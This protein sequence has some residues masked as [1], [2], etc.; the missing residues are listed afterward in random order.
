[1]AFL[2]QYGLIL[3]DVRYSVINLIL[4]RLFWKPRICLYH[5]T[6]KT[7]R[8]RLRDR[9]TRRN[10]P[11]RIFRA[12][13][14]MF[15]AS[16]KSAD[17]ET[18][19]AKFESVRDEAIA[20]RKSSPSSSE[21]TSSSGRA[22]EQLQQR[23]AS[24]RRRVGQAPADRIR[25]RSLRRKSNRMSGG[26]PGSKL[27]R[28]DDPDEVVDIFPETCACGESLAG[29]PFEGRAGRQ[30]YDIAASMREIAEPRAHECRRGP[31]GKRA[32]AKFP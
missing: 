29:C 8:P 21:R 24:R 2:Q 14:E 32:N 12:M 7:P 27:M 31:C 1:M 30:A 15:P 16:G 23:Q 19:Q 17:H 25:T 18:I 5:I 20:M 4:G 11:E 10:A 28:V 22:P 6:P 13:C 3:C 9:R 26:Q